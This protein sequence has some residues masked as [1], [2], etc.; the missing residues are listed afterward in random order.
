ML[1]GLKK[2]LAAGE[3]LPLTLS[4]EKA[5]N[6]SMTVP[7]KAMGASQKSQGTM[8]GMGMQANKPG[9]MGTMERK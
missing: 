2:P 5:E 3:T 1:I 7:V 6:I 4:F 8:S 9:S